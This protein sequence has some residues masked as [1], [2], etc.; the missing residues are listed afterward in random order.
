M[1]HERR[2]LQ[3]SDF[4]APFYFYFFFFFFYSLIFLSAWFQGSSGSEIRDAV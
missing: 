1:M 4:P 2:V 3:M